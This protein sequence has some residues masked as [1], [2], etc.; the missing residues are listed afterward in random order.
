M[1]KVLVAYST[2]SGT[3]S[4]VARTI[5]EE[6]QKLPDLEVYL[7]G[8]AEAGD[9]APYDAYLF[10]GPMIVGW[11]HEMQSFLKKNRQAL[12]NK[13]F[14]LFATAINLTQSG[15]TSVEGIPVFVDPG[16]AVLPKNPRRMTF[17]ES[18]SS[19][20]NYVKPMLKAAGT[21]RP[22][23]VALFGG[24][25]D[26]YRLKIWAALFV[27]LVIRAKPGEKRNWQVIRT[28]A[29]QVAELIG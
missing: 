10:G 2:M 3:T 17:K 12:V 29:N 25:L 18:Y 26:L 15:E 20:S 27:M 9:L 23:S 4:D 13:P 7:A 11:H 1:K 22:V 8:I 16:L 24:R 5:F 21:A 19:I 6:L 28:W 14:A